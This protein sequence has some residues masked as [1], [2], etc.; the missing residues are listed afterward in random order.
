MKE[1]AAEEADGTSRAVAIEVKP[2]IRCSSGPGGIVE[3]A[4]RETADG[5][6]EGRIVDVGVEGITRDGT[7]ENVVDVDARI[8]EEAFEGLRPGRVRR[9]LGGGC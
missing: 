7:C 2:F 1:E 4:V 8:V 3:E 6:T 5:G 9:A